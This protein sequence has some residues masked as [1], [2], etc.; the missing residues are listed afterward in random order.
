MRCWRPSPSVPGPPG[1]AQGANGAGRGPTALARHPR[2]AD[3]QAVR[4]SRVGG[5]RRTGP[6]SVPDARTSQRRPSERRPSQPSLSSLWI[7]MLVHP[8]ETARVVAAS[9][10]HQAAWTAVAG[11]ATLYSVA[12]L[13]AQ[14]TG[15]RPSRSPL[16]RVLPPARYYALGD[17]LPAARDHRVDGA[18]RRA[19]AGG[20]EA[21]RRPRHLPVGLRPGRAGAH[22]SVDRRDVASRHGV[23]RAQAGRAAVAP[24]RR[25]VR[26]GRDGMGARGHGDGGR[27]G[28][29]DLL[30]PRGARSDGSGRGQCSRDRD[31][32]R[33]EMSAPPGAAVIPARAR[34]TASA[35]Q[36]PPGAPPS[37]SGGR[38]G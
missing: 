22:D 23:L 6:L 34:C 3:A 2:L 7:G 35:R 24:A 1:L 33:H 38:R 25:G 31:T 9:P 15:R 19:R 8:R 20:S 14:L 17:G 5:E 21:V 16:M 12:T 37:R 26:A 11:F 13:T 18:P 36:D 10:P 30:A 29:V 27:R 28:R 32:P 4:V